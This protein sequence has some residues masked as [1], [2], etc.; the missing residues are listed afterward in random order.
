M[1]QA[2]CFMFAFVIFCSYHKKVIQDIRRKK[3]GTTCQIKQ[4]E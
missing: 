2:I 4:T 3:G 1:L